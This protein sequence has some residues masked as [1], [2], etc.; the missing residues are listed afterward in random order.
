MKIK[1]LLFFII[2]YCITNIAFSQTFDWAKSFG[3]TSADHVTSMSIDAEGNVYLVG[4]SSGKV[5][6]DPG[7]GVA[8]LT[9]KNVDIYINK[10]DAA[11]NYLWAKL[12]G[13][14]NNDNS[15]FSKLDNLGNL[16]VVG[17]VVGDMNE[18]TGEVTVSQAYTSFVSKIDADG[19]FIWIKTFEGSDYS[20]S[21]NFN[22][23]DIGTTG[24]IYL[25]GTFT[26]TCNFNP[27]SG[28]ANLTAAGDNRAP[29]AFIC[30][31]DASGNYIWAKSFGNDGSENSRRLVIDPAENIYITGHF[32]D[33]VD[34]DPGVGVVELSSTYYTGYIIGTTSF[35]C[36]YDKDGDITWAKLIEGK[37][38]TGTALAVDKNGNLYAAGRY[39]EKCDV[40]PGEAVDFRTSAGGID[41]YLCKLA[42]DG[43]FIW[44][45][46]VGGTGKDYADEINSLAIDSIEDIYASG[47][48]RSG[49]YP[50]GTNSSLNAYG[51]TD[52][53][54]LKLKSD[55]EL[56]WAEQVG[57]R[58][59]D[60]NTA[61]KL[62][63][64]G[65]IYLTGSYLG[66]P[67][68]NPAVNTY[69]YDH[70]DV[71]RSIKN[72]SDFTQDVYVVKWTQT[73]ILANKI[74]YE[75]LTQFDI[76]PNPT[77]GI[78]YLSDAIENINTVEVYNSQGFNIMNNLNGFN[79]LD[80][81]TFNPGVYFIKYRTNNNELITQKVIKK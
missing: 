77:N 17:S 8:N 70:E 4:N 78:V 30:K 19:N 46:T 42:S 76:Y 15:S 53:F 64:D 55:G 81:S 47:S 71:I 22:S 1:Q 56:V 39:E 54:V 52:V 31:L 67:N 66:E 11:G 33:T 58:L 79:K 68:F 2:F 74:K 75:G 13:G 80:L 6:F 37:G 35:I 16:F 27:N 29:D 24:N 60:N 20:N 63:T 72:Y 28:T 5:D 73:E 34:F 49:N 9:A 23:F 18:T 21:I 14:T 69:T 38:T 10:L 12:I 59:R 51:V 36:K 43:S 45:K 65:S 61:I 44:A 57:G 48:F 32:S 41:S 7:V 3:G 25:T 26:G 50:A 40:N 62:G